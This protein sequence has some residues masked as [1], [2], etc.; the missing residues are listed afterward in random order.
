MNV[1]REKAAASR[2]VAI[3]D[4]SP[5][6]RSSSPA[7]SYFLTNNHSEIDFAQGS[8]KPQVVKSRA[9]YRGLASSANRGG[10]SYSGLTESRP[11]ITHSFAAID[12]SVTSLS[13]TS[14]ISGASSS[15][16]TGRQDKKSIASSI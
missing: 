14:S 1:L 7:M 15:S 2:L 9:G 5:T 16:S 4:Q 3:E 8:T 6:R 11:S 13:P 12:D 10:L